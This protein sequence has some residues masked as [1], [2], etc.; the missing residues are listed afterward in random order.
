MPFPNIDPVA[1]SLGPL[2]LRWY[3]IA[4]FVGII[5]GIW[6]AER[7]IRKHPDFDLKP[8][9]FDNF[10]VWAVAGILLGG[11]L[12]II[13]LY[14]TDYYIAHP[15]K[16]FALNEGGMSF[17]GGFLGV[18]IAAYLYCRRNRIPFL[19]FGDVMACV[20]G[21]GIFLVRIANFIN[22]ELWGRPTEAPWGVVFPSPAAGGVA[23]HP[24]Q[25]YEAALEG[26]L[27]FVVINL[28][29]RRSDI[30]ARHGL[31]ASAFLV[32]YAIVR[33]LV[34]FTREPDA[35]LFGALTRGQAYS[36]PMLIAGVVIAVLVTRRND[37]QP[38][39]PQA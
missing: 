20:S 39:A 14:N 8:G 25:L 1:L 15:L 18:V 34:E 2:E 26:V 5:V 9:A 10:V 11:R 22:G 21:I 3:G 24:S 17:H 29:A 13:L 23:R 4:Y 27:L 7:L 32:G 30:R 31:L 28:M 33:G 35:P 36:L 19:A 6:Y 16:V 37:N 12:G 38:A